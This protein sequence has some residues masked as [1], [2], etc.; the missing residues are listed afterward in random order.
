MGI[1]STKRV[2]L[3]STGETSF[4]LIDDTGNQ[5]A[6]SS[7]DYWEEHGKMDIGTRRAKSNRVMEVITYSKN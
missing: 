1:H 5:H 6:C 7:S 3:L 4:Y 2:V